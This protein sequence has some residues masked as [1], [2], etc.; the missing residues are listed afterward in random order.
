[1]D[2]TYVWHVGEY[3]HGHAHVVFL[4]AHERKAFVVKKFMKWLCAF[5]FARCYLIYLSI[6]CLVSFLCAR[7]QV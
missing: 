5:C 1:M 6:S 3:M 7:W 2:L 4:N